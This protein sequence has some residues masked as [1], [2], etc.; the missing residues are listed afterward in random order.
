MNKRSFCIHGHFYQPPR[1]D[2]LTGIIPHEIGAAP[3]P[4]W[5]ERIHAECYRP[6]AELGN[7]ERISFNLGP[8]LSAWMAKYDPA[9][10]R[11]IVAQDRANIN[12]FGIGNAI[13]QAYNHT[14]LPLAS[15]NDKVTQV[16][17]G[18]AEFEHRFGRKPQGMWLPETAADTET[19]GVLAEQGI[20]FTILAPW[21]ANTYDLDPTEP[22]R[23]ALPEGRSIT[24]F[25]YHRELSGAVSFNPAMT[26]NADHFALY[27]LVSHYSYE[28]DQRGE[29][30]ILLLASDGELYGHHQP[31]RDRFLARLVDGASCQAGMVPSFP[32]LWLQELQVHRTIS[33]HEKTSWSCLHGVSRWM[34][35]CACTPG[36][37]RWKAHLRYALERLSSA[38]DNLYQDHTGAFINDPW[39]MRNQYIRVMLGDQLA[40][41]FIFE[42]A[43]RRLP[44][45]TTL[46]I[47]LLLEAQR[48]RQRMYTSCG[49]FFDDFDRIEPKN[50]LAYAAQAVRLTRLATGVDLEPFVLADLQRVTSHRTRL[51][52]DKVFRW[53]IKRA[54]LDGRIVA[55]N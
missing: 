46:R 48:E 50:N 45:E 8:T 16:A 17:W 28:K 51:R 5:N 54:V 13:A 41:D 6:N 42:M 11:L 55:A 26:I 9:T 1:D 7:F 38:L 10:L 31:Q 47:H 20:E 22:Y 44:P 2:P 3:F 15:Y 33:L 19:L 30:Q 4:N 12:R 39:K 36:D 25:F 18:I 27:D 43:G 24:V 53:H 35:N 40:E 29:P 52:G 49:W 23:V 32:G 34:G 14:I 37:G 21:Q